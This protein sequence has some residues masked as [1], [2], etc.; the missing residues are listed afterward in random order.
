MT[1]AGTTEK[2]VSR[3]AV[4]SLVLAIAGFVAGVI[5]GIPAIVC[6]H[7]A[8]RTVKRNALLKGRGLA[9]AGLIVAYAVVGLETVGYTIMYLSGDLMHGP[10]ENP[11]N[12][13]DLAREK[14]GTPAADLARQALAYIAPEN[15]DIG[16]VV[17]T[18]LAGRRET[19][20]YGNPELDAATRFEIGSA[21]KVFTSL[22]LAIMA[23]AGTVALTDPIQRH[24]PESVEAPAMNSKEVQLQHLA[25]HTAGLPRLPPNM[26]KSKL[27]VFS[28]TRRSNP[29]EGYSRD[30]L[31]EGVG[32]T[33]LRA[34]PGT[35]YEY[36]NFGAGLLGQI[37]A[38]KA[39]TDYETL[40]IERIC[41]PLKMTR[42]GITLS[43]EDGAA[44]APPCLKNGRR[45]VSWD[46][47]ALAGAGG[48]RSTVNDLLTFLA[49]HVDPSSTALGP[50]IALTLTERFQE[51][52]TLSIGL[53]WHCA[54]KR[55]R[56]I[57][58]HNGGT[59]GYS[60]FIGFDP[61][62]KAAVAVLVNMDAAAAVTREGIRLV[63]A[64]AHVSTS[65]TQP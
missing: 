26:S 33:R 42:T 4:F 34:E 52:E 61:E 36:S 29:Y 10:R 30:L 49:A 31:H 23:D 40:V 54:K 16:I 39:G 18:L 55:D 51:N 19:H 59:G 21:T 7:I 50:A 32:L 47:D 37:L 58:W 12:V 24:L 9:L 8:R 43:P 22:A 2:K 62:S 57:W 38:D 64:L 11:V 20:S 63:A 56:T 53:G 25:S 14:P 60:S 6:G 27:F 41:T 17:G 35:R 65:E 13:V 5:T 46:L 3:W 45:T 28:V 48:L 44:M 1:E 15:T